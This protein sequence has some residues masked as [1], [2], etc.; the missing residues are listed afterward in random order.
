MSYNLKKLSDY[1]SKFNDT[2]FRGNKFDSEIWR[3]EDKNLNFSQFSKEMKIQLKL[4]LIEKSKVISDKTLIRKFNGIRFFGR[5]IKNNYPEL[6]SF[7]KINRL[8]INNYFIHVLEYKYVKR[9]KEKRLGRTSIIKNTNWLREFYIISKEKNFFTFDERVIV[10]INQLYN[11]IIKSNKRTDMKKRFTTKKEYNYETIRKIIKCAYK[12]SDIYLK[13][14]VFLQTQCGLRI[15]EVLSLEEDCLIEHGNNYKLCYETSKTE[16]GTIK[17]Q[18]PINRLTVDIIN[19]LIDFTKPIRLSLK[20]RKIFVK[21]VNR[22]HG[23]ARNS[24]YKKNNINGEKVKYREV[25]IKKYNINK[26]H[27]R[28]FVKRWNIRED[29]KL[30]ELSTHY[31]RHFFAFLAYK[32]G[33]SI[34]S[35]KEMMNHKSFDMTDTYMYNAENMMRKKFKEMMTQTNEIIGKGVGDYVENLNKTYNFSGKTNKQID[36][37][38]GV[39]NIQVLANGACLHHPI[40]AEE[41]LSQCKPNCIKC[42]NFVTHRCYLDVHKRRISRINKVINASIGTTRTGWYKKN[43]E[44]KEYI[45]ENFIKPF[46]KK[47]TI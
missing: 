40:K 39:M 5:F 21:K 12:D 1:R 24:N 46:E 28:P 3:I 10:Y 34:Q 25:F 16:L 41:R 7:S 45:I 2:I 13:S 6:D 35:I 33:M 14:I 15:E 29:G 30:I 44:E 23:I 27:I 11:K 8:L 18:M 17:V 38:I 47:T 42:E 4:Y 32:N 22:Y 26:R 37:I 20:T 19:K 9:N 36:A 43:I 31:F